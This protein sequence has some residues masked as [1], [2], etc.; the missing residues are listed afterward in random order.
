MHL[1]DEFKPLDDLPLSERHFRLFCLALEKAHGIHIGGSGRLLL[2]FEIT[3]TKQERYLPRIR[4]IG[5]EVFTVAE[6]YLKPSPYYLYFDPDGSQDLPLLGSFDESS[7][8]FVAA[9]RD[10]LKKQDYLHGGSSIP[11]AKL[12]SLRGLHLVKDVICLQL[13][14]ID[15]DQLFNLSAPLAQELRQALQDKYNQFFDFS[16]IADKADDYQRAAKKYLDK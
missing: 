2:N 4:P 12:V 9:S 13:C 7:H 5:G 10:L 6:K 3:A 15:F 1:P 8:R 14:E 16:A 11:V